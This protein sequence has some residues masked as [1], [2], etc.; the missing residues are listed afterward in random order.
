MNTLIEISIAGDL[1][2]FQ[3]NLSDTKYLELHSFTTTYLNA[4]K[5]TNHTFSIN[6]Y[7]FDV[8]RQT[9]I[10]LTQYTIDKVMSF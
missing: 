6:E 2:F 7:I 1:Y 4:Q 9:N 3:N 10:M 8:Y 5:N